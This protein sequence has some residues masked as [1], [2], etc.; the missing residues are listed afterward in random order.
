MIS[1]TVLDGNGTE[2][3]VR[4]HENHPIEF[5]IPREPN[6][7]LPPMEPQNA[8]SNKSSNEPFYVDL[9]QFLANRN[10]TV[11][12][13]FE[14]RPDDIRLGYLFIYRFDKQPRW[15]SGKYEMDGWTLFCPQGK[16]Q[17]SYYHIETFLFHDRS[18]HKW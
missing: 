15:N 13:H 9:S 3:S 2:R 11:S 1:L 16:F 18:I 7:I 6:L 10:L 14:I 5:F 17:S 8:T 12:L 4:A